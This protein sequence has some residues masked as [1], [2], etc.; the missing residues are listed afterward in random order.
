M[1]HSRELC[2]RNCVARARRD[3]CG[4]RSQQLRSTSDPE[5]QPTRHRSQPCPGCSPA[6]V[7]YA[8]AA[9]Q[10]HCKG[11]QERRPACS[12]CCSTASRWRRQ[13][14]SSLVGACCD[15][16]PVMLS[17]ANQRSSG[18]KRCA[19]VASCNAAHP[20]ALTKAI[21]G[22]SGRARFP[23]LHHSSFQADGGAVRAPANCW[24]D[25]QAAPMPEARRRNRCNSSVSPISTKKFSSGQSQSLKAFPHSCRQ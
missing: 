20:P 19:R 22:R 1:R 10:K 3:L 16:S 8:S 15:A 5:H 24:A 23:A 2:G 6:R 11:A 14:P 12:N 17:N 9:R 21:G 4:T 25:R 18:G 13:P 7:P